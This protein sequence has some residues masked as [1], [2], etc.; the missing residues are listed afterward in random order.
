MIKKLLKNKFIC[1]ALI[2]LVISV[3]CEVFIF[4]FSSWKVLRVKPILISG[5]AQTVDGEYLSDAVT[6]DGPVKNVNVSLQVLN[7]DV[8]DVDVIICST[9]RPQFHA[10]SKTDKRT[11][12]AGIRTRHTHFRMSYILLLINLYF[13]SIF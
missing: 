10:L 3:I 9:G 7:Y 1:S 5:E 11:F 4:N 8:A 2:V 6:I 13:L 12:T